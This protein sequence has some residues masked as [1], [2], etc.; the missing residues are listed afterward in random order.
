MPEP[1]GRIL[2]LL[3][4]L[5]QGR[6][7]IKGSTMIVPQSCRSQHSS[8]AVKEV[9]LRHFFNERPSFDGSD[10]GLGK[11]MRGTQAPPSICCGNGLNGLKDATV[12]FLR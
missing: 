5:E 9:T 7:N 2:R 1:I 10:S 12:L 11:G 3:P 8:M 6:E 4:R